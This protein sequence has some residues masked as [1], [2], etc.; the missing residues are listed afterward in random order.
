MN[1]SKVV[2]I[3]SAAAA[4]V[5]VIAVICAVFINAHRS[6]RYEVTEK[7][8]I[9]M[10]TVVTEKI[11][12]EDNSG[13]HIRA[14]GEL[15]NA[16]EDKI[17]RYKEGSDI[18]ALNKGEKISD[19]ALI[20]LITSLE[21]ISED[22]DGA[23][24]ITV[25]GLVD[26]WGIGEGKEEVP[27]SA[28]IK[29]ELQ[30][31]G[32][33]HLKEKDGYLTLEGECQLD[34]GA[35]GKGYA[36][37][38]IKAYL[39]ATDVKGAVISVGGS[40]L[41]YGDYNKKGDKWN[42]AVRH[43]RNENTYLGVISLDEGFVSTSGDYERYF[44]KDGERYH[45]IFDARTGY[46]AS[47]GLISVTVVAESGFLSDALSTACFILGEEKGKA[48]LEKYNA[49]GVFVSEDMNITTVGEIDFEIQSA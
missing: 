19:N 10:D 40:I 21:E 31:I 5:A 1:K 8:I 29:K 18:S 41:A 2:K 3:A 14:V 34:L 11:Y 13:V 45:H 24:D 35:V 44:E 9:A 33:T 36:C 46:P 37:D 6:K 48:L 26:L 27:D 43:P 4:V 20:S 49:S 16:L 7:S 30:S 12:A 23:F 17:S 47:S 32:Y 38:I 15:I 39:S 25:G 42:V 22:T 28:Q